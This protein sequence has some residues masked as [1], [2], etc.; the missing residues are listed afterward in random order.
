LHPE[1]QRLC[2]RPE[3]VPDEHVAATIIADSLLLYL[4]PALFTALDVVMLQKILAGE[5]YDSM[6][7]LRR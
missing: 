4:Q 7:L 6:P 5:K 3:A 2:R 1:L